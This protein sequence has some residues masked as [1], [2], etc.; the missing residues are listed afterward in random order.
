MLA[1]SFLSA[2]DLNIRPEL[3]AALIAELH[4]LERGEIAGTRFDMRNWIAVDPEC[5]TVFCIGGWAEHI[6]GVKLGTFKIGMPGC[7]TRGIGDLF[8]PFGWQSLRANTSQAAHALSN[9]LT[10][11]NPNWKEALATGAANHG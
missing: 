9:Y 4:M 7:S 10:T 11:G 8:A 2:T 1:R 3:H 6:A 5:G